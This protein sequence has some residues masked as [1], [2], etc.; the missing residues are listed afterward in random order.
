MT[1]VASRRRRV[2]FVSEAVTL[3]HVA[4]P[5]ALF[6]A[7]DTS[8]FDP[9][10]ACD[11]RSHRFLAVAPQCCLPIRSVDSAVFVERLRRGR[12]VYEA[13]ELRDYVHADLD[14]IRDTSPDL[15]IGDFRLSLSV[16]ARVAGVPYACIANAYWSPY[17][18][19]RTF[20]L[21]VL[22]WTR[23]VPVGIAQLAFDLVQDLALRPHCRP[24]NAIRTEFGLEP[25][26][27]DVR[28]VYTDADHVLYADAPELFPLVGAPPNHRHLGPVLWSP[29]VP[30]PDWW[31]ELPADRPLVYVTMG[32]SGNAR[33]LDTIVEGLTRLPVGVIVATAGAPAPQHRPRRTWFAD[34][35]PGEIAAARSRLVVCNGGSPTSQQALAAG[36]PVVGVCANMDQFLNMRGLV[37]AGLGAAT[38]ADRVRAADVAK[39]AEALLMRASQPGQVSAESSWRVEPDFRRRFSDFLNELFAADPATDVHA[40]R[41]H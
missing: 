6:A 10:L 28:R 27:D 4:R 30:L 19:D 40:P 18:A 22:P 39:V 5:A 16:S 17:A 25:L 41:P 34:Y 37:A 38:R 14:L 12:P 1:L 15:I 9:L 36:V 24:L 35:L 29:P 8:R 20:P 11:S 33:L 32:S 21:P 23:F 7:V 31:K 3:A 13:A 26:A 2:L